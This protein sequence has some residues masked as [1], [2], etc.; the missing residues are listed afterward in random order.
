MNSRSVVFGCITGASV[1]ALTPRALAQQAT[2]K[3]EISPDP[4]ATPALPARAIDWPMTLP[5]CVAGATST[6]ALEHRTS[7]ADN[8]GVALGLRAGLVSDLDAEIIAAPLILFGDSGY[9]NPILRATYRVFG[10]STANL[11]GPFELGFRVSI[12][13]LT[14]INRVNAE[15]G[16]PFV[17]RAGKNVR[18]DS[19]LTLSL[20]GVQRSRV[21]LP[22]AHLPLVATLQATRWLRSGLRTGLAFNDFESTGDVG[23]RMFN[24]TSAYDTMSIPAGFFM[25]FNLPFNGGSFDLSPFVTFPRV[26]TPLNAQHRWHSD[27]MLG[28]TVEL[29]GRV[30]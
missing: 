13:P 10:G 26:L 21:F 15:V 23:I 20:V 30:D 9:G 27:A 28:L 29:L 3:G 6:V 18:F 7:G 1:F 11:P 2:G 19:G 4:C 5:A 17:A 14:R 12:Q 16:L 8:F 24:F 22:G 25:G